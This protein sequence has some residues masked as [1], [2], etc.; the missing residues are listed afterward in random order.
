MRGIDYDIDF[1]HPRKMSKTSGI[2]W[3]KLIGFP[4]CRRERCKD[5]MYTNKGPDGFS[6]FYF[7]FLYYKCPVQAELRSDPYIFLIKA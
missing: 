4:L 3:K 1:E 7:V 2:E 5:V 6:L